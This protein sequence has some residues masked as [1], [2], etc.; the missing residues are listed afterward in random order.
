MK[1]S[2]LN[3]R[4]AC[5][6]PQKISLRDPFTGEVLR[7]DDG[8]TLDF[9]VYGV[10]SDAARNAIKARDRKHGKQGKLSNEEAEQAGA[11][12]LAAI[13]QGW[14]GPLEVDWHPGELPYTPENAVELYLRED[15]VAGQISQFSMDLSNYDPKALSASGSGSGGSRGST[16]RQKSKSA[17]DGN[18]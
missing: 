2:R 9:Y 8:Q 7:D 11:E 12:Y 4:D 1:I 18:S 15:W 16:S 17:A 5:N 3:T 10:K 6:V 13:T 14:K